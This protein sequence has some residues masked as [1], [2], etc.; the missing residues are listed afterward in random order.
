[1]DSGSISN[2]VYRYRR[3]GRRGIIL[4]KIEKMNDQLFRLLRAI[5][6]FERKNCQRMLAIEAKLYSI[7]YN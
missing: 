2:N 4:F 7:N 5:E 1:M 3:R 6:E